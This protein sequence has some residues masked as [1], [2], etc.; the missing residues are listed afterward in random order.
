MESYTTILS[1]VARLIAGDVSN[2]ITVKR[3]YTVQFLGVNNMPKINIRDF[4]AK[5]MA[6]FTDLYEDKD[7]IR[8]KYCSQLLSGKLLESE[9]ELIKSLSC[10]ELAFFVSAPVV[11]CDV[12]RIFSVYQ[13][14]LENNRRSFLF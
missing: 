5:L 10:S 7:G 11:S 12:E 6:E 14:V 3:F 8:C 9:N 2:E 4:R 13:T 1:Q